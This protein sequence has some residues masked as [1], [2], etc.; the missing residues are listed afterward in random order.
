MTHTELL[1]ENARLRAQR[2]SLIDAL[3]AVWGCYTNEQ[4]R[5][6][7]AGSVVWLVAT[8][9]DEAGASPTSPS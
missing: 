2:E 5:C 7:R 9:L 4:I 8:A 1:E 6:A 3:R